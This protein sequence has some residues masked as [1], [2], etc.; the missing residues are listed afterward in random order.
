MIII[1]KSVEEMNKNIGE[2][3]IYIRSIQAASI[4]RD[5]NGYKMVLHEEGKKAYIDEKLPYRLAVISDSLFARYARKHGVQVKGKNRSLDFVMIKFDYGVEA[6]DSDAEHTKQGISSKELRTLYYENGV[7]INWKQYDKDGSEIVGKRNPIEYKMLYRSTGKAKDGH[8]IFCRKELHGK[9]L[10]Y[11]TMDLWDKMPAGVGAKIVEMSAYA[12]LITATATRFI[13]IPLDNIFVIRDEEAVC[14]KKAHIVK[15]SKDTGCYVVRDQENTTIKNVL[16]DGMGVIDDESLFPQDMEGFIY[17]RSHFF[18]SCLFRGNIQ[19]YFQDYYKD[20]YETAY[21]TDMLG[22]K[23]KVTDIK[24]IVTDNSLKWLKFK[25]IMSVSGTASDAFKYYEKIMKDDGEI[26]EIVKTAHNSKYG[27]Q[28]RSSFQI[29]N[30]LLTTDKDVLHRIAAPSIQYCNALK[31]DDEKYLEFLKVTGSARYSINNVLIDLYNQN[32]R[33]KYWEYF[34]KKRREKISEFKRNRLQQGKLFQTGDNLTICGN[35]IA[36]LKKVTRQE[37]LDEGCFTVMEDAIQCYT[38]R[39]AEGEEIAGF[40]SP[41][42]SPN[43]IVCL[44]NIYP[45][46]IKKYFPK[47][48][49]NVIVIN[50]IGTDVQSRLNGQD[51]DTDGIYATNHA[52]IVSLAKKAYLEYPTILNEIPQVP[53]AYDKSLKS[54]AEMDT[55]ISVNQFAI[56]TASNLAQLALSYWFDGGCIDINLENNFIICSVLAQVAIDS[57]KR[58]F[59]ANVN[60]EINRIMATECMKMGELPKYPKFYAEVLRYKNKK[61]KGKKKEIDDGEIRFFNCPMDIIYQLI[62]K[63]VIDLRTNK[64]LNTVTINTADQF[65]DYHADKINVNRSQYKKVIGIVESY[66]KKMDSLNQKSKSNNEESMDECL[67][68]FE[69]CMNKLKNLTIKGDTMKTLVAFALKNGNEKIRDRLLVVLYE[70]NK[71]DFLNCFYKKDNINS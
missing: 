67:Q 41:H 21:E 1:K 65:V 10:K 9:L 68:E 37:F 28:Q 54:Y 64:D 63:E 22:R 4:Y 16:W 47:L 66:S 71:K 12:P 17:C 58:T 56:G 26:F 6:D 5:N 43:N 44:K 25:E 18:K 59:D 69:E 24:V 55:T 36:L 32:P 13:H 7:T 61:K 19:D 23:M 33:V 29:N 20:E 52:D 57:A 45:E 42:N 70:K 39:F 48:G 38:E 8:C 3:A 51:L 35:V 53:K 46:Q 31:T 49:K 2:G 62:E 27:N 15:H 11:L 60:V 40:R 34:K 30:T 14:S 50:G